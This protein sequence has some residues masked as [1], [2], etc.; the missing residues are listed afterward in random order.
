MFKFSKSSNLNLAKIYEGTE[1]LISSIPAVKKRRRLR[2]L[3][4][5]K[6]FLI[7]LASL[8][9]I[10]FIA[11]SGFLFNLL[12]AYSNALAG[13]NNLDQ[14]VSQ[15]Q[16]GNFSETEMYSQK[17][18]EHFLS[19]SE[20]LSK[21]KQSFLPS[22]IPY[23]SVQ[24]DDIDYLV[25]TAEILS[26]AAK[27]GGGIGRHLSDLLSDRFN[28]SFQTLSPEK[29]SAVL[30]FVYESVPELNGLKADLD[31][32][33][34]NLDKV[35]SRGILRPFASKIN[36]FKIQLNKGRAMV[37]EAIPMAELLPAFAG[38]PRTSSFLVL[39]ENDDELRPTGG[40]IGTFGIMQ[41]KNGDITDFDTHDI[42]HLD[43]PIKD[44]L[45][46]TPP[47]PLRKYLKVDKWFM[48]DANWSPDWP[49]SA[50]AI[51][52]FYEKEN[53][54][55]SKEDRLSNF[56]GKFDGIIAIT[57][58]FIIDLLDFVGPIVIEGD[59]YNKDNFQELLQYKVEQEYI[60]LGTPSWQRK[61]VIGKIAKEIKIK[62]GD[63][64][65]SRWQK[66]LSIISEDIL[67][68]EILVYFSDKQSQD[69][70]QS[71][72]WGGEIKGVSGD[73]LMVVD[74]NLGALKTDAVMKKSLDYKVEQ[75]E[76]GLLAKLRINYAHGGGFDWR[77]TRYRSYTRVYVPA[78]SRLVKAEGSE[79]KVIVKEGKFE[80]SIKS[81][82]IG[83]TSFEAFIS[84]E[85]GEIGSLYFEYL[86]PLS[87][88]KLAE[89]G[90]YNLYVQKQPGRKTEE[91]AFDLKLDN[92]IRLY[93]PVG[94][95]ALKTGDNRV[96]WKTDFNT[97]KVFK[98]D[99]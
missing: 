79:E 26:R 5:F 78:G 40:F 28:T 16:A 19:A 31:L 14:A 90:V 41:V 80:N 60:Q 91:L 18:E 8:A 69:L 25:K 7:P 57:P 51:A 97:D 35:Q 29:K 95:S 63:M 32:A 82:E 99:F 85:P 30:K 87:I 2:S 11:S 12:R 58:K 77:T 55:F 46:I 24:I 36:G 10:F 93:S 53:S 38:Y 9:I 74:A 33:Y 17:A 81:G 47:E 34:F 62:L 27:Q 68:K 45:N 64:P 67:R 43:M 52:D 73:Y 49:T 72:G 20:H 15:A 71:L 92:K 98:I 48:R 50:R 89:I 6:K 56:S 84:I 75:T 44:R 83:K 61:E 37:S 3:R 1:N 23:L 88:N 65:I 42:Y 13:K 86:L 94:F 66:I 21:A 54:L 76:A 59:Q 39:L 70:A 4:F 96:G 22:V